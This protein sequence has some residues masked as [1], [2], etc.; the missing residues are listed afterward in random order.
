M[1]TKPNAACIL[2]IDDEPQIHRFLRPA[3]ESAGF[4]VERAESATEG[5]RLAASRAPDAILLDLGLPDMDGLTLLA[6]LREFSDVPV[7][8]LSARDRESDKIAALDGGADDYVEK[9]FGVG[10]LLARIRTSLRHRRVQDGVAEIIKADALSVDLAQRLVTLDGAA[11]MLSPR[12][13][14]L[15]ELLARNLGRVLTHRQ[16][17][18]AVWGPAHTEDVQYLR[19]YVG[20]LRQK[21]GTAGRLIKTEP[22]VGYRMMETVE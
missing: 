15:L 4:T 22:G 21:L 14:G 5:L 7:L 12:E 8:V 17:L 20:Q 19:V 9:P 6:R 10:E 3:L 16:L 11:L 2:V 18:T 1:S 13:W